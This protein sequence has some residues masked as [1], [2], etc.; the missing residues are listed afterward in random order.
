MVAS[1]D[2]IQICGGGVINLVA[3]RELFRSAQ[4]F[5]HMERRCFFDD[6]SVESGNIVDGGY[7]G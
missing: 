3:R 2:W 7:D 6:R 5:T 4:E 1:S